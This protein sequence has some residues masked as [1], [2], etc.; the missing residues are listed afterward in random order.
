M[1][2]GLHLEFRGVPMRVGFVMRRAHAFAMVLAATAFCLMVACGGSGGGSGGEPDPN[3]LPPSF[4]AGFTADQPSPGSL[5]VSMLEASG[6]VG[7]QVTVAVN[8][9]GTNDVF[10]S[11]LTV[12]FDPVAAEFVSLSAG[13]L[14][15]SGG[16][17]VIYEDALISPGR[18]LVSA[19]RLDA[20]PEG[21]DV[22]SSQPL[23][24]LTFRATS[25][26]TSPISFE[27]VLL[28]D[29]QPPAP[30]PIPGL[31]WF[32]GTLVAN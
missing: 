9:T 12:L 29:S 20:V 7:D 25:A 15:E 23:V 27:T 16:H 18:L 5:T 11:E 14:L 8:V 28:L 22:T 26:G 32:G 4:V 3:P 10:G 6:G 21:A 31:I 13:T 1:L 19:V 24:H 17:A 30:R 2:D